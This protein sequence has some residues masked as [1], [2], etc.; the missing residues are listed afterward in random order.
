MNKTRRQPPGNPNLE[1]SRLLLTLLGCGGMFAN[2][3]SHAQTRESLAGESAAE[4]LKRSVLEESY[5]VRLG[6]VRF[7]TGARLGVSYTDNVFYSNHTEDDLLVNPEVD[8]DA[9]WPVTEFNQLKLSLGLSYEWYANHDAL[10]AD[11]PLVNPG[12][13][14]D[15]NMFV[16]DVR[17]RF[18]ERFSYQESLF[19]NNLT[20]DNIRFY[21]F[22]DV[23]TFARFDNDVGVAAIWDLDKV[24]LNL[25]YHHEN[26]I[27]TTSSFEYLDR[28]SEWFSASADYRL[29]DHVKTGGEG[30]VDL[31]DYED[32]TILDDNWRMRLG[33]FVEAALM[34]KLTLRAG[35]GYD[36]AR[37]SG[38]ARESSDFDTWYGYVKVRQETRRFSHALTVG[39]ENRLGEN[40]NNLRTDYARYSINSPVFAHTDL[41]ANVSVNFA[42]EFGGAF[43]EDFTYYV[44]GFRVEYHLNDYWSAELGYEFLAKDSNLPLRDIDR[45]RVTLATGF[46][47]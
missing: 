32:E 41:E 25:G 35:A 27:S 40:A 43:D 39:R 23:G 17:L 11:A 8:L 2:V 38:D 10:N 18:H 5:N 12:S 22:N 36:S 3:A 14:L 9:L 26:F 37:Y 16:G 20:G 1:R 13:E 21:N 30:W 24:V 31:H 4:K 46:T 47:F 19:Y 42:E 44:M 33:P 34:E 7:R 45:N 15:F 28:A 29:G 6:P